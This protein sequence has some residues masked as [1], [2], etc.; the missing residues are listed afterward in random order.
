MRQLVV[1]VERELERD[2]ECLDAHHRDRAD[3]RADGEVDERRALAVHW[4]HLPDHHSG[5]DADKQAVEE[6]SL[7]HI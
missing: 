5:K 4:H 3:E 2:A 7:I 6:L 1:S